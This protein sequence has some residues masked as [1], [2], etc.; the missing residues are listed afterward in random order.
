MLVGCS[1]GT[2][3]KIEADERRP[4]RQIATLLADVLEIPPGQREAF[5]E[6]A[7]R[8]YAGDLETLPIPSTSMPLPVRSPEGVSPL[9]IPFT[10]LIGRESELKE[11]SRLLSGSECRLL[12]LT[13]AGGMGKTRLA[14]Q[15]ALA[16]ETIFANGLYFIALSS[17]ATP[18]FIVPAVAEALGLTFSGTPK[19]KDELLNFLRNKNLLL[20]LDNFEHLVEGAGLLVEILG[21]A[22]GVKILVTSRERLNLQG[23]WVFDLQ[24]LPVPPSDEAEQ[25]KDFSAV[26]LF[27]DNARRQRADF[28]ISAEN[29]AHISR[30][31]R[32]ADGLPLG[33]EL[34]ATWISS[35][36][37]REIAQEIARN[38]DFLAAN[39]RNIPERHRSIRAVFD[40]SWL[41][42]DPEAQKVLSRLSVFPGSFSRAAAEQVAGASLMLLSR[43]VAKSLVRRIVGGRYELHDLL[44]QYAAMRLAES[45]DDEELT[46]QRH[47]HYYLNLVRQANEAIHDGRQKTAVAEITTDIDNVRSAWTWATDH[48][49]VELINGVLECLTWYFE[50]RGLFREGEKTFRSGIMALQSMPAPAQAGPTFSTAIGFLTSNLGWCCFRL[51]RM[52]EAVEWYRQSEEWLRHLPDS[53]AWCNMLSSYSFV[54]I[55]MGDPGAAHP[56]SLD[57]LETARRN[58]SKWYEGLAL[59]ELGTIAFAQGQL[60]DAYRL[61]REGL[62]K[63]RQVGDPRGLVFCI[64]FLCQVTQALD[65]AEETEVLL[66]EALAISRANDDKWGVASALKNLGHLALGR[67]RF[68]EARELVLESAAAFTLLGDHWGLSQADLYLGQSLAALGGQANDRAAAAYFRESLDLAQE[69]KMVPGAVEALLA[70]A[71]LKAR[72]GSFLQAVEILYFV[73]DQH[74]EIGEL[75][76]RAEQLRLFWEPQLTVE[77]I[78][79]AAAYVR[80][81]TLDS[82][83]VELI[84]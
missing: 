73:L 59:T 82:L 32:L 35:L 44:R 33:I 9:P 18:D 4:S 60:T 68:A 62:D 6:A 14:I 83:P 66:Q 69:L 8:R 56:L 71:E 13:G 26:T 2:I 38:L 5:Y 43:L 84:A 51:N 52:S 70:L 15:A 12:T 39:M 57:L 55:V 24:G 54:H 21:I 61:M 30:I 22:P 25:I 80:G 20:V 47:S 81:Q 58:G 3:R 77:Q 7:R 42:L 65:Y 37:C 40:Q 76:D 78:D 29:K 23:E 27:L 64:N 34:A 46:Y 19:P 36:S 10:P 75:R 79:R 45:P 50:L 53:A 11:V 67:G 31:C 48:Q 41:L 72:V 74:A 16:Q 17:L 49:H 63:W 1:V 28:A